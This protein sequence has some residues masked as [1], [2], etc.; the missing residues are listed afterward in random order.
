MQRMRLFRTRF[1]PTNGSLLTVV[2]TFGIAIYS[3]SA[4]QLSPLQQRARDLFQQ[5]IEINTTHTYGSTRAA[6]AMAARLKAAG[7]A[8][9]DIHV[10][11]A[12]PDKGNLIARLHGTGKSKPILFLAHLDVVEAKPEDWSFEPFKFT[13]HDGWF[14]GRGTSDI[15][16]EAADLVANFIRLH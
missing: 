8:A 16:N 13:E 12:R 15:K 9:E 7:F 14:Y 3:S 4:A 6:E 10:L 11:G 1:L 2:L 5:L